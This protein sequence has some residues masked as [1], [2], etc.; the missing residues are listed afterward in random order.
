MNRKARL[1]RSPEAKKAEWTESRDKDDEFK[2]LEVA[3]ML[4]HLLTSMACGDTE[5]VWISY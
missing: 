4:P 3:H 1:E 5:L 2:S